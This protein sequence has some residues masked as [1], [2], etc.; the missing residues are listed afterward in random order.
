M[1]LGKKMTEFRIETDSLG[2]VK[3]PKKSIG[4]HKLKE[5]SKILK[6]DQIK[7]QWD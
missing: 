5:A 7:S 3:V 2:K 1:T 6:L 4:V